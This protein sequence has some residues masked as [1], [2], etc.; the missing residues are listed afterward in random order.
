[1]AAKEPV[2]PNVCRDPKCTKLSR[3][4]IRTKRPTRDNLNTTVFFGPDAA[5]VTTPRYCKE[6]GT[7]LMLDLMKT[8]LEEDEDTQ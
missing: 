6:H 4:A 8:L 7:A 5:P 3:V 2:D 1:M